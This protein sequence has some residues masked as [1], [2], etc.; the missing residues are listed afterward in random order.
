MFLVTIL[1]SDQTLSDNVQV[2][3]DAVLLNFQTLHHFFFV[4]CKL[5][6]EGN[7]STKPITGNSAGVLDDSQFSSQG[8]F[9]RQPVFHPKGDNLNSSVVSS[10]VWEKFCCLIS[11]IGWPSVVKCLAKGKAF[12]DHKISQVKDLVI[13]CCGR[14]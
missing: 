4:L 9:L 10:T 8:G 2:Q 7:S 11:E 3:L 6:K 14:V 1:Y 13:F 5:I 12:K